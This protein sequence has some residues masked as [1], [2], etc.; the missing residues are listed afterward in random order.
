MAVR[1]S[2]RSVELAA[3]ANE[4]CGADSVDVDSG[5]V[6]GGVTGPLVARPS[7]V[8][9]LASLVARTGPDAAIVARGTGSKMQSGA[10]PERLDLVIETGRLDH[11]I[12]HNPGDL[13]VRAQAGMRLADLQRFLAVHGQTLALDSADPAATLGGIVAA[14]ESGPRRHRYGTARDVLIGA[15]LVLA[16]GTVAR[17]GGKVVK[18]VAGYDLGKLMIGSYGTLAIIA[19]VA[20]RLHPAPTHH[21]VVEASVPRDRV[22][23]LL[24]G[25]RTPALEPESLEIGLDLPGD[26]VRLTAVFAGPEPSVDAQAA[27]A[28]ERGLGR[29]IGD[30]IDDNGLAARPSP[31]SGTAG[32]DEADG[33]AVIGLHVVVEPAACL[34]GLDAL[35]RLGCAGRVRGRAALGVLDA[36]LALETDQIGSAVDRLRRDLAPFDGSVVITT[37]PDA[38]RPGLDLWGP[39]AAPALELMRSVKHRFDPARRLAPGRFVGGI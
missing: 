12:E 31:V 32:R 11:V 23:A 4:V 7:S 1:S 10:T 14:N 21:R 34:R 9:Q 16:D 28:V 3:V 2:A 39:V 5:I 38:W 15:T 13:V 20:F 6:I 29:I 8:E 36:R 30:R 17:T 25:Y 37:V 26:G 19:E 24:A 27:V 35:T 22:D 33:H 18:N